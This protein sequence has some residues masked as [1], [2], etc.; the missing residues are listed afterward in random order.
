ML[1][2]LGAS[3]RRI[4]ASFALRA[5][6]L[7][8][9]AGVVA[10]GA[11]ILGG[12]AVS[13]FVMETDYSVVWSNALSIILGGIGASMAAGLLFALRPLA[14]KPCTGATLP[15]NETPVFLWLRQPCE[16]AHPHLP[17]PAP[18]RG[19]GWRRIWRS[20]AGEDHAILSVTPDETCTLKGILAD[21]PGADW[22]ALDAR[23]GV[24][25]RAALPTGAAIYEVQQG[26]IDDTAPILRS[27]L[28]VVAQGYHDHYGTDGVAHFFATTTNWQP[29]L[30]DR[31]A[32]LYP[33]HQTIA[34]EVSALVDHHLAAVM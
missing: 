4:F 12:W 22:A 34:T 16:P 1:K 24:Y 14:A 5:A 2:T 7:G 33:R 26:I 23:E 27:Y 9:A 32:P 15:R 8:L 10:L 18:D 3:R 29:V 11:G 19:A 30:D 31:P 25:V 6:L 13:T 21:V 17:Q 28:D 20:L